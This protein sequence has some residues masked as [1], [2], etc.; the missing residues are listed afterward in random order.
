[1]KASLRKLC[2]ILQVKLHHQN[3]ILKN[4]LKLV[5]FLLITAIYWLLLFAKAVLKQPL[6]VD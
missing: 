5:R 3:K 1:M 6:Q 4:A 2:E